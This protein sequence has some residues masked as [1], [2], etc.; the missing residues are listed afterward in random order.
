MDKLKLEYIVGYLPYKVEC[1]Y[2]EYSHE[3][4]R[5]NA[6]LT[7]ASSDG[8]E[9]TFKRKKRGCSGDIIGFKGNNNINDLEFKLHLHDLSDLT[10][11]IEVDGEKF[12]PI[13]ELAKIED[14]SFNRS[15]EV[16]TKPTM[17]GESIAC[18]YVDNEAN[19]YLL[20]YFIKFNVFLLKD[21]NTNNIM[22]L[23]TSKLYQKLH[24]WHFDIHN[25]IKEGLA[26]SI[27]TL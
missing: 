6:F 9:T 1:S 27:N 2:K 17:E 13:V 14:K 23:H 7:G 15:L 19:H 3:T 21:S 22:M 24:E 12:V 11:E 26:V 8:I 10:K 20:F 18:H 25:L 4:K 5:F 16:F